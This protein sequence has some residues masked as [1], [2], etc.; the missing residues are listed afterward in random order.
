MHETEREVLQAV[1]RATRNG[2][3]RLNDE[4]LGHL[5]AQGIL[6]LIEGEFLDLLE[7]PGPRFRRRDDA[8]HPPHDVP[9]RPTHLDPRAG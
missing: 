2:L 3:S 5:P 4:E 8:W 7:C 6:S 1:L 9:S